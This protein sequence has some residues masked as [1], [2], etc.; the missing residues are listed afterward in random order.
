[1]KKD[2]SSQLRIAEL[3]KFHVFSSN[4]FSMNHID[5]TSTQYLDY[6]IYSLKNSNEVTIHVHAG[7]VDQR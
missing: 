5:T 4:I 7:A 3:A 1:M 6:L 2:L